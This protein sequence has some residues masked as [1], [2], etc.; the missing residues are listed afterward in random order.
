MEL[1]LD[2]HTQPNIE[3]LRSRLAALHPAPANS[4]ALLLIVCRTAGGGRKLPASA[5]LD[6][7]DGLVGDRWS[8]SRTRNVDAQITVMRR[9]VAEMIANGQPLAMFGDN[10]LVDIDISARNL[11]IGSR[12]RI[13]DALVEV[14]PEPHTGCSKFSQRFGSDALRFT[15]LR[16]LRDQRLR[17][18]HVRVIESGHV[19]CGEAIA[20]ISRGDAQ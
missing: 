10:L 2:T 12:L 20:V 11:P 19:S 7:N 6:V 15:A 4:G 18:V 16:E 8:A 13:G 17:G 5:R 14:T 9:D 3:Q 1:P